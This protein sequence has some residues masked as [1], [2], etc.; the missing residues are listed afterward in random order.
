MA[1][2]L[3]DSVRESGTGSL[4]GFRKSALIAWFVLL[5]CSGRPLTEPFRAADELR[6]PIGPFSASQLTRVAAAF[7]AA[8]FPFCLCP[9]P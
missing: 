8:M 7:L 5:H 6:M 9:H 1:D 4:R 3:P 2:R